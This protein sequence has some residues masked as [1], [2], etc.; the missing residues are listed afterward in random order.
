M[1]SLFVTDPALVY[2][3]F[4]ECVLAKQRDVMLEGKKVTRI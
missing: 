3:C 4:C 1:R 2:L